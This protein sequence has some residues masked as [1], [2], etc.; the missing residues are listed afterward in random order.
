MHIGLI[1]DGNRRYMAKRGITSL[2]ESYEMGIRKFYD[3]AE[4]CIDL[5]IGEITVYALSLENLKNRRRGEVLLLLKLFASNAM[6]MLKS[7]RIHKNRIHINVCGD[8]GYLSSRMN[9]I[10]S[11]VIKKLDELEDLTKDYK[12]ITLNLAI[13][14]GGRQEIMNSI[15]KIVKEGLEINEKNINEN[16]WV[17]TYP[18]IIIRT[19]ES[20]LSNFMTWQSAYS[21][22]YFVEKLWQEFEKSDLIRIVEDYNSTEK[23]F[24]R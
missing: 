9:P 13:A 7:D 5:G 3:F 6:E 22:I 24:G 4:W 15:N 8:R 2:K 17:K 23:R 20:R 11:D 1:P 12:D 19:A 21:E 14:Y 18:E 10:G 16:L